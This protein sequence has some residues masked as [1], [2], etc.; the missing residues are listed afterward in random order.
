MRYGTGTSHAM[1]SASSIYYLIS[2]NVQRRAEPMP[3]ALKCNKAYSGSGSKPTD[4]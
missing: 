3:H 1:A 2:H 4:T